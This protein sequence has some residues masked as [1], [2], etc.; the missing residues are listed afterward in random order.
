MVWF[1]RF[2]LA[3]L[4]FATNRLAHRVAYSKVSRFIFIL[5]VSVTSR[6]HPLVDPLSIYPRYVLSLSSSFH[7]QYYQPSKSYSLPLLRQ[8]LHN[9]SLWLYY[10]FSIHLFTPAKLYRHSFKVSN[11]FLSHLDSNSTAFL[12]IAMPQVIHANLGIL[13]WCLSP[14]HQLHVSHLSFLTVLSLHLVCSC[15]KALPLLGMLCLLTLA[16]R[17]LHTIQ[18]AT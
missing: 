1:S 15:L 4:S 5:V 7:F 9:C 18:I 2:M 3:S 13:I 6:T 16:H 10:L 11:G 12:R 17:A 8:Y 14:E